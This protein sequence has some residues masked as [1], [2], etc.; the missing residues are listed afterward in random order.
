MRK[1]PLDNH[2]DRDSTQ[3]ED[4]AP[5]YHVKSPQPIIS[6]QQTQKVQQIQVHP[7]QQAPTQVPKKKGRRDQPPSQDDFDKQ[8]IIQEKLAAL[9]KKKVEMSISDSDNDWQQLIGAIDNNN[10]LAPRIVSPLPRMISKGTNKDK[11][12]IQS[13]LSVTP[14]QKPTHRSQVRQRLKKAKRELDELKAKQQLQQQD[15]NDLNKIN[16]EIPDIQ[17][18]VEQLTGLQLSPN[19]ESSSL[20]AGLRPMEAGSISASK[21]E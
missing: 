13:Q 21:G 16:V 6:A 12:V 9:Q 17:G 2:S 7:K 18:T 19:A 4:E 1:D 20:N 11:P 3:I 14:A 8:K 5:Q 15:N 10:K